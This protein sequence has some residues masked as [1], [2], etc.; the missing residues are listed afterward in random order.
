M[1]YEAIP[2]VLSRRAAS[3]LRSCF[4][5]AYCYGRQMA[6]LAWEVPMVW[7]FISRLKAGAVA[8]DHPWVTGAMP[9]GSGPVWKKNLAYRSPSGLPGSS[10]QS[11]EAVI[12][13]TGSFLARMVGRSASPEEVPQGPRRRMP[14][15]VNYIHGSVHYNGAF[16]LFD[17]FPD[18]SGHLADPSFRKDL[19][20]FGRTEKREVTLVFRQRV[21]DPLEYA[22]CVGCV[23]AHLPWF[24]NGNGPSRRPVLWGNT[25]PYP[26]INLINGSWMADLHHLRRGRMDRLLREPIAPGAHFRGDYRTVRREYALIEKLLAWY[27]FMDV[28]ARGFMGQLFFT[29]RRK[30]EPHRLE[31]YRKAGGYWKWY[32]CYRVPFPLDWRRRKRASADAAAP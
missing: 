13:R 20:R 14:H 22:W 9:S 12:E 31:E 6:L 28:R 1:P 23:R 10:L 7:Y 4:R 2:S 25:A 19:L 24:S 5:V 30:I 18:L 26:A 27:M 3:R 15:A 21:Y 16:L 8:P 32:A 11:D 17:D 29:D